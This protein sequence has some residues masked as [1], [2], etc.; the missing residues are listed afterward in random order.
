MNYFIYCWKKVLVDPQ[1]A[2]NYS[3]AQGDI[4]TQQA[5]A[6]KNKLWA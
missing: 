2:E 6:N 3:I 1:G 4:K 5:S